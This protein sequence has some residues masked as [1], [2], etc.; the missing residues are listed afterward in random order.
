MC[1]IAGFL[2]NNCSSPS[3]IIK[4]MT[5]AI[6]HR[7]PDADGMMINKDFG[8]YFGHRRLSIVDLSPTGAQPMTSMD[9][10]FVISYNGEIYNFRDLRNE[11]EALGH[12]FRG[13]SDTEIMLSAFSEWGVEA[14]IPKFNGMFAF[15]LLDKNLGEFFLIRDRLGVKPLYYGVFNGA[16]I[17]ASEIKGVKEHPNFKAEILPESVAHFMRYGYIRAPFS[18]YKNLYKLLPGTILKINLED[19][20]KRGLQSARLI[21]YWEPLPFVLNQ[22]QNSLN[23]SAQIEELHALLR[24]SIGIRMIADVPLG[25][26]LSGGIDSSTVVALM[27]EQSRK[28]VKTFTIGFNESGYNEAPQA[29]KI[30]EHLN[31]DHTELY[32]TSAEAQKCIPELSKYYDE[33]FGDISQ[34]PTYLVSEMTRKHVTVSLSGDGGDELFLG[35]SRYFAANNAWK[36]LQYLPN[37]AWKCIADII[38]SL[39]SET[40]DSAIRM[41]GFVLPNSMG[42]KNPGERLHRFSSRMIAKDFV[43]FYDNMMSHWPKEVSLNGIA[44]QPLIDPSILNRIDKFSYMSLMDLTSYLPDDI[45]CKLDRASMAHGLE[46]REPLLDYRIVEYALKLPTDLKYRGGRSKW[47]LR[48][49]L[50]K[51]IPLNLMNQPKMG[52]GVPIDSWLR[53]DLKVWANHLLSKKTIAKQGFFNSEL[54]DQY[55]QGHVSGSAN[56]MYLLWDVLMFQDWLT[57]YHPEYT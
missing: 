29:K 30:A 32:I 34:I 13:S 17:F 40:W 52:F 25:A 15:S 21:S 19:F 6:S 41:L 26:F 10:R 37:F 50:E 1:G 53:K 20:Y 55:W 28:P 35:Y 57:R 22:S 7:G 48:K 9:G 31:T 51:Y 8:T 38:R 44:P 49:V 47:I 11:L 2:Q 36:T 16:L 24:D 56:N 54:I 45:F 33:P 46:A 18:I 14:S 3:D 43:S 12:I 4:R 23:V 42:F 39:P 27:Q 5:D